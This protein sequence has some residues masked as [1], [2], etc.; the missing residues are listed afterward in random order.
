[1][2]S[3]WF[4]RRPL[5]ALH[6]STP[7]N[8]TAISNEFSFSMIAVY[9]SNDLYLFR[10]ENETMLGKTLSEISRGSVQIATKGGIGKNF[11][12]DGTPKLVRSSIEASLKR[13]GTDYVD[14]FYLARI[15]TKVPIEDTV[16]ELK[17]MVQEG[18]KCFL[19]KIQ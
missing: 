3:I 11:A 14:L 9:S 12:P 13:L 7:L 15:D 5:W 10:G 4:G 6:T 16:G 18:E 1:M 2:L 8:F 19:F 17:L